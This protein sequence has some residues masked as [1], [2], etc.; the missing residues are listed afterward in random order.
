MRYKGCHQA[1][2]A[3]VEIC[4]LFTTRNSLKLQGRRKAFSPVAKFVPYRKSCAHTQ[5]RQP[6]IPIAFDAPP[7]HTSRGFLPWRF[8]YAGPGVRRPTFMGPASANL[9]TS[10]SAGPSEPCL[11]HPRKRT[12][13]KTAAISTLWG[14]LGNAGG[15]VIA[16]PRH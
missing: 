5:A 4:A 9:H 3:R 13:L 11:L 1:H 15:P 14:N 2:H 12:S 10:G 7:R 16:G 8:A 6:S